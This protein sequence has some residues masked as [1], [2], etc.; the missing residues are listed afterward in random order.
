[1]P[2][3]HPFGDLEAQLQRPR[4]SGLLVIRRSDASPAAAA[5]IAVGDLIAEVDGQA[6]TDEDALRAVLRQDQGTPTHRL[7]G[8]RAGGAAFSVN[9]ASG[10]SGLSLAQVTAGRSAWTITPDYPEPPVFSGLILQPESWWRVGFG[11]ETAGY[12]RLRT[13]QTAGELSCDHFAFYGGADGRGGTFAH[14]SRTQSRHH[15]DRWLS[16]LQIILTSDATGHP[17]FHQRSG[18]N[19]AGTWQGTSQFG[20]EPAVTASSPLYAAAVEGSQLPWLATT[21]PL[22]SQVALTV[23]LI[24]AGSGSALERV[25]L[26]CGPSSE[27]QIAGQATEVWCVS[28]HHYGEAGD[29]ERFWVDAQHQLARIEWGPRY[30][31][32]WSERIAAS[33]AGIGLPSHIILM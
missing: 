5:G 6:V 16:P 30:N 7:A 10:R 8:L 2:T 19:A 13:S 18:V 1:M 9:I 14:R 33:Q 31:G 20:S 11:A 21:L 27:H 23:T 17:V 15:L 24:D 22:R 26:E 4:A 25:R 29:G 32:A 12:E 3:V 28:C